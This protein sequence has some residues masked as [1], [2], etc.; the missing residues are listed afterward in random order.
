MR[1][2]EIFHVACGSREAVRHISQLKTSLEDDRNSLDGVA[3]HHGVERF[4][5]RRHRSSHSE[6]SRRTAPPS[7]I[8]VLDKSSLAKASR[9]ISVDAVESRVPPMSRTRISRTFPAT[10]R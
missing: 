5:K 2:S 9:S 8:V 7:R 3:N 10:M 4:A 6:V 1:A